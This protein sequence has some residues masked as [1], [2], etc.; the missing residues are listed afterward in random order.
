[1][2][3]PMSKSFYDWCIENKKEEYLELWDYELNGCNSKKIFNKIFKKS[4][5]ILRR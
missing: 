4:V 2:A 5:D 3:R 1:M